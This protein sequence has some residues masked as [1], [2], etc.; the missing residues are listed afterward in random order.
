M[1]EP[2]LYGLIMNYRRLLIVVAVTGGLGGAWNGAFGV[3]MDAYV[4]H[5]IFSATTLIY[6]PLVPFLVGIAISLAVGA[7]LTYFWGLGTAP[8]T[9]DAQNRAAQSSTGPAGQ[10][11]GQDAAEVEEVV[12]VKGD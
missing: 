10:E 12:T 11:A 6:S 2:I 5:N 7:A 3:T 9:G 8:N 4:F 1:T